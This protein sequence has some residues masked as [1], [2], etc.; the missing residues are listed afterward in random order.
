MATLA[1]DHELK[2]ITVNPETDVT[3]QEVY[4]KSKDEEDFPHVA[5]TTGLI[6]TASGKESLGGGVQVGITVI[7]RNGWTIGF[8]D[9]GSPV[10]CNVTGGNLVAESEVIGDQ[11]FQSTNVQINYQSSTSASIVTVATSSGVTKRS[12]NI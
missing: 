2:R 1:F 9:R 7:M 11:F 4:N 6:L 10:Q 5:M 12:L 3:L 8:G